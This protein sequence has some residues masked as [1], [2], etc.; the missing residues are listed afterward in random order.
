MIRLQH[1]WL[2]VWSTRVDAI[3]YYEEKLRRLDEK[4]KR[5][6]KKEFEPTSLAFVTM[7]SIPAA[8]RQCS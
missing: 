5:V 1:G 3:D 8:V 6:R 4:I 7:D 2:N